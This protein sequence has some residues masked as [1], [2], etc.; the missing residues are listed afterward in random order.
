[1]NDRPVVGV[2]GSE[3]GAVETAIELAGGRSV[4]GAAATVTETSDFL[5][6]VGESALLS[7]ARVRPDVP[8]LPVAAGRGVGSVPES[9]VEAATDQL[10]GGDWTMQT[11]RLLD[12][13]IA[14]RVRTMAM[15]DVMLV[16]AEPAEISEYAV[17]A[18]SEP[19]AQFRADGVVV[20][21]PAG[22]SGYARTADGPVVAPETGVVCAVPVAP[23]ATDMD[24]WVLDDGSVGL[25]VERSETAVQLQVDDTTVG[26][27]GPDDPVTLSAGQRLSVA[28]VAESQSCFG[29]R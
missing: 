23:F 1:M 8:V 2:V 24:H 9:R 6:P 21:T 10:L 4:T 7:T 5:V 19:V 22:S 16:T 11:H 12:V 26:P 13:R 25:T 28:I 3:T 15:M 29:Q 27:V 14:D 17:T 20:A 18:G